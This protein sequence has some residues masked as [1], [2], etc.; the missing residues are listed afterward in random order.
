M[1]MHLT[2]VLNHLSAKTLLLFDSGVWLLF[3]NEKEPNLKRNQ[4]QNEK[5]LSVNK[6]YDFFQHKKSPR[7]MYTRIFPMF[8]T[9]N[10]PRQL[11]PTITIIAIRRT[12]F[13]HGEKTSTGCDAFAKR[14]GFYFL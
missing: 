6:L 7:L 3:N 9:F 12:I 11:I 8:I 2:N 4:N 13:F 1:N 10:K 5:K 14:K